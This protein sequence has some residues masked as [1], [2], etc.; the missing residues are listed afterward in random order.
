[1]SYE[2]REIKCYSDKNYNSSVVIINDSSSNKHLLK[3]LMTKACGKVL[4]LS[5]TTLK[6]RCYY[7]FHL[8]MKI[9]DWAGEKRMHQ[10][11]KQNKTGV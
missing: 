6:G 1:M 2:S 10:W 5:L 9:S 11:E 8:M 4:S 3:S 7:Y